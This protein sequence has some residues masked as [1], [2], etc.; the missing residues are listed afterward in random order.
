LRQLDSSG[1]L[2]LPLQHELSRLVV[3]VRN[4]DLLDVIL[5]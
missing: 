1:A 4:E 2:G 5:R 3:V